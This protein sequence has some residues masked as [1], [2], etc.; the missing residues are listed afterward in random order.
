MLS[1]S[2]ADVVSDSPITEGPANEGIAS[3]DRNACF[4]VISFAAPNQEGIHLVYE[5]EAAAP[6]YRYRAA[7]QVERREPALRKS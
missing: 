1:Y 5:V 7:I 4:I 3:F 2:M 6:C